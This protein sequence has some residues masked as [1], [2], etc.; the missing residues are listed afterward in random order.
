MNGRSL[1]ND[2]LSLL[3]MGAQHNL[4]HFTRRVSIP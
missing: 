1:E 4:E 2:V 3:K